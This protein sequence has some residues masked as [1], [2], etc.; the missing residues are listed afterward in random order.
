MLKS[1]ERHNVAALPACNV[2]AD[3]TTLDAVEDWQRT[4]PLAVLFFLGTVVKA[5]LGNIAQ[6]AATLGSL[7]FLLQQELYI[8]VM[9]GC[10][11][12]VLAATVATLRYWFF[13]FLLEEGRVRIREGVFKRRELNV[14]FDRIQGINME[15]SPIF[16]L[17][18][19]A[20]VTFD[21]AG[22]TKREGYLPAVTPAFV[23]S[24]RQH[25]K[26][27]YLLAEHDGAAANEDASPRNDI[28][29]QLDNADMIRIGVTDCSWLA[30]VL[31]MPFVIAIST[32]EQRLF[33]RAAARAAAEVAEL[34]MLSTL[35]VVAGG[36]FALVAAFAAITIVSAF[37]R[38]HNF[39]LRQE[40]CALYTRRGFLTRKEMRV[41]T[42][43]IQQLL[44]SQG[45]RLRWF[46]RYRLRALSANSGL[47][48]NNTQGDVIEANLTVPLV[49]EVGVR[50]LGAKAFASEGQGLSLLPNADPFASISPLYIRARLLTVGILPA[51]LAT[52]VLLPLVDWV[53][54]LAMSWIPIVAIATWRCW[55]LYGYRHDDHGFSRR[56]G[57]IGYHVEVFLFRKAQGVCIRRSPLQRRKGLATLEVALASGAVIAVP[58]IDF[59]QACQLRDYILYKAESSRQ[60]WH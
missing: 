5:A 19:L 31:V 9:V 33:E 13:R 23:E 38:F 35:G 54:F 1:N 3:E 12:V 32:H 40:G 58:F 45:V 14:Q 8:T 27:R 29:L 48:E 11:V 34:D 49:D 42:G 25:I 60:S 7:I 17:L 59:A 30:G 44:V 53:A 26:A 46:G 39:T 56:S 47:V 52:A 41:E 43:K 10:G 4:S 22:S 2:T 57:L 21:T 20:T 24:L 37:L 6:W 15:Q 36:L 51:V 18:G 50:E 16:R 28:L 55:R